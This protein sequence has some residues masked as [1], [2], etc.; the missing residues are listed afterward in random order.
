MEQANLN[1]KNKKKFLLPLPNGS[2]ILIGSQIKFKL[3]RVTRSRKRL[4][5]TKVA[6]VDF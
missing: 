3:Y 6:T 4:T 1:N 2:K 5:A